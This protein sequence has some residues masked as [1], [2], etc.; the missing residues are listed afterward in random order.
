VWS[1]RPGSPVDVHAGAAR[2]RDLKLLDKMRPMV[3]I[4]FC[5]SLLSVLF[6]YSETEKVVNRNAWE[7]SFDDW[8]DCLLAHWALPRK[9]QKDACGVVPK[10]L[11]PGAASTLARRGAD[12]DRRSGGRPPRSGT[13][14]LE[15]AVD[16]ADVRTTRA[17]SSSA[18]RAA[19]DV[20][21]RRSMTRTLKMWHPRRGSSCSACG[22]PPT[23]WSCPSSSSPP[24]R[25][26]NLELECNVSVFERFDAST[27]AVLRDLDESDRSVQ[28]SAEST[29]M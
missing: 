13:L 24:A 20:G 25:E 23:S 27:S 14:E 8:G 21:P 22:G 2:D 4:G 10:H 1:G 3:I 9:G 7:A 28:K 19:E 6:I 12:A 11:E 29:S 17:R 26:S 5:W 15:V 18:R 16:S